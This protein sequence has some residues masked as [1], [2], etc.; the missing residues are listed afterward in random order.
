MKILANMSCAIFKKGRGNYSS[1]ISNRIIDKI[2]LN[3]ISDKKI[4]RTATLCKKSLAPNCYN[5]EMGIMII[6]D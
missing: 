3:G 1:L 5:F 2:R 6:K 4:C